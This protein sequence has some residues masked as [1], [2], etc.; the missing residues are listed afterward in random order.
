M[1]FDDFDGE[2]GVVAVVVAEGRL[3]DVL[4]L[5]AEQLPAD[6][7]A[8]AAVLRAWRTCRPASAGACARR[9]ACAPRSSGTRSAAAACSAANDATSGCCDWQR[10]RNAASWLRK[11]GAMRREEGGE[12][13]VDEQ[14]HA[15][16][17]RAGRRIAR[18][19]L[20]RDRIDIG[21]DHSVRLDARRRAR[22]AWRCSSIVRW[23][24][25][26]A[27]WRGLSQPARGLSPRLPSQH[28]EDAA[29]FAALT[30]QQQLD[31]PRAHGRHAFFRTAAAA[32]AR[33]HVR[34]AQ[35]GGNRDGVGWQL[36]GFRT[37]T[38]S[39]R[40]SAT[41]TGTIPVSPIRIRER[42][43][44]ARVIVP[45]KPSTSRSWAPVRPAAS[46]RASCRRPVSSSAVRAGPTLGARRTSSTMSSSTGSLPASPTIPSRTRRPSARI[47]RR[48]ARDIDPRLRTRAWSAA[49][50]CTSRRI[51][52]A[53][54]RSISSSAAG[55]AT[56]SGTGF[57]DWPITYAELEPYYT[58]VEWEVGVSGLA[59][60]SPFDPPRS[61]PY[62]MPPMPV[63][64]SGVLF[65]RGARKL[66]LHP[67]P[68]PMAID[69][70]P[71]A[72]ARPACTAASASATAAKWA[73]SLRRCTR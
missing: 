21:A 15:R 68:A 8:I 41:T 56:I 27:A 3:E 12:R 24:P 35:Y 14:R 67:F 13:T 52:G 33:R 57:A 42:R 1:A 61:K 45:A 63:K 58:K 18:N 30:N 4:V 6:A 50:A 16:L 10:R 69:S 73:R 19:D 29:S 7:V 22:L 17:A 70:L 40:P 66:G 23:P 47:Q 37:S 11:S 71:I 55:S 26:S 46:W 2:A 65:E 38:S 51:T 34:D 39:S 49:A 31:F 20:R 48:R 62:P 5:E 9:T 43:M 32:D 28:P 53:S 59:G 60:A 25:S 72:A 44:T 64:S 36:I 54:T